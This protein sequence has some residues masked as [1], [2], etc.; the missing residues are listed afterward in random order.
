MDFLDPKKK[1]INSI[2]LTLGHIFMALIVVIGT[3]ILVSQA[4]GFDVDKKTGEVYQ[5]GLIYLDSAPDKAKITINGKE[6]SGKTNR[7]IVLP[8]GRYQ[9][10]ISKDGYQPWSREIIVSGGH[11]EYYRYPMLIPN[12][13]TPQLLSKFETAPGLT[14][15][16]PDKRF[17]L[18]KRP[19]SLTDFTQYDL[20]SLKNKAPVEKIVSFPANIFTKST[21][22]QS[23]SL[24]EW[25]TDNKH[26]I[27]KHS[28]GE[29]SEFLILNRDKP[30][31]SF[32]INKTLNV[33][34]DSISLRDKNP[35]KLYLY[36]NKGGLLQTADVKKREISNVL[37]GVISF[38]SH[39]NDIILYSKISKSKNKNIQVILKD[40]DKSFL[41]KEIPFSKSVPLEIT[42]YSDKWIV[43][44]SSNAEEKTYVFKNPEDI[45]S[46]D[47]NQAVAPIAILK[48]KGDVDVLAFSQNTQ[49]IMANSG[50]MFSVYDAENDRYFNYELKNKIDK[51]E[52][53]VWMDGDRIL[54]K[55]SGKIGIFDYDGINLRELI[56]S[57]PN[58]PVFF[59]RDYTYMY[60]INSDKKAFNFYQ[61]PLRLEADL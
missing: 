33:N 35:N 2:K 37:S 53:P 13:L 32:N 48:S 59:N 30:S 52:L 39:G 49:F 42:K 44:I 11:V 58:A 26:V 10:D 36:S 23:L 38:K 27:V 21:L 55:Q 51:N 46:K 61:T 18:I 22:K 56:N 29:N 1:R 34:P 43:A 6:Q 20:N 14:L 15:S 7:R 9:V 31:D 25:S 54:I 47:P 40:K 16:S 19:G 4:Y 5:N 8:E 45:L 57:A 41:V 24:V 60:S 50:Q 17:V 12:Q 28:I 3:Y